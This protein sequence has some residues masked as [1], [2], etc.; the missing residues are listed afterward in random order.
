MK[1]LLLI[2]IVT[3]T[4]LSS[5]TLKNKNA[6]KVE[7]IKTTKIIDT[8][9][10][11]TS[12]ENKNEKFEI[13]DRAKIFFNRYIDIRI[14]E[15]DP[16]GFANEFKEAREYYVGDINLDNIP[17]AIV[18]YTL[19]GLS[20]GNNWYRYILMLVNDGKE[21]KTLNHTVISGT[22][23]GQAEFVGIKNGY[24]VFNKMEFISKDL[25]QKID[26]G[27]PSKYKII[28]YGIRGDN[29]VIDELK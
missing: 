12:L 17:D 23:E 11:E 3:I 28:G 6:N 25:M 5:C 20:G 4:C 10:K 29:I 7:E 2:L 8:T 16:D 27:Q 9:I 15:L 13:I 18:L 21:F 26:E 1:S 22:L 14:K 19:E 24:A